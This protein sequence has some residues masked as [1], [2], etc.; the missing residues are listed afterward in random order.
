MAESFL[1]HLRMHPG[2]QELCGMAMTK[3]VEPDPWDIHH[4]MDG[5]QKFVRQ[6]PR[7]HRF[8]I[9]P[10]TDEGGA[11]LPHAEHQQAFG[12]FALQSA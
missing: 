4:A 11:A 3:I 12:L 9:R 8:A 7:R 6:A 1:C 5:L 10:S 2:D